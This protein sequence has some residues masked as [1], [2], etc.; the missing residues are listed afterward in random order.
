MAKFAYFLENLHLKS[1]NSTEIF[2][3]QSSP[4]K[5]SFAIFSKESVKFLGV[6]KQSTTTTLIAALVLSTNGIKGVRAPSE[7]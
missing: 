5:L 1:L 7:H 2:P 6:E 4:Y 3:T